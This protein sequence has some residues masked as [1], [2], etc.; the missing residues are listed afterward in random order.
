MSTPKPSAK[1]KK[2]A[3]ASGQKSILGFFQRKS[4]PS[5]KPS[6]E[7]KSS[8]TPLPAD[9]TRK[10]SSDFVKP[11][12]KKASPSAFTPVPSSDPVEPSSPVRSDHGRNKENGLSIS[13]S[14]PRTRVLMRY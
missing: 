10:S 14:F 5:P 13:R 8:P 6:A 1:A 7:P 12:L 9:S 11:Q 4:D 2:Q 3:P